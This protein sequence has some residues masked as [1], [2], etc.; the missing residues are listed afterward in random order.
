MIEAAT[1]LHLKRLLPIEF[2][3]DEL[4]DVIE[5]I[6]NKQQYSFDPSGIE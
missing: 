5:R 4:Q 2:Q 3:P 1:H 6:E